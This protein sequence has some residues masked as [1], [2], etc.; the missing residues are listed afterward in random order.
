MKI[1]FVQPWDSFAPPDTTGALG[2]WSWEVARRFAGSHEVTVFCR[3][4][5]GSPANQ[6]LDG[7]RFRRFSLRLDERLLALMRRFRLDDEQEEFNSPLYSR[8]FLLRAILTPY[9][10][11]CDVLHIFNLSQFVPLVAR[12]NPRAKIVL[13]MH[14]DWLAGFD[15]SVMNHRLQFADSIIGCSNY[16]THEI[17]S[18]F[19]QHADRCQTVYNGADSN[20]FQPPRDDHA[21]SGDTLLTVGRISPEKGLHILLAAF[22]KVLERKPDTRLRIVGSESIMRPKVISVFE[23]TSPARDALNLYGD[24]YLRAL[25]EQAGGKLEGKVSFIGALPYEKVPA[26]MQN[27]SILV[28]PSLYET[29]GMPVAEAMAAGL[30][31]VASRAGG[32]AEIVSDGETGMLVEPNDPD[33]LAEALLVLLN[34]PGLA[35]SMG[36]AGRMRALNKFS[37]DATVKQ[38]H[39]HYQGLLN[40]DEQSQG[41]PERGRPKRRST[42]DRRFEE[43]HQHL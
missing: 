37:W 25:K 18:R 10:R 40:A 16:I 30:P 19:P 33:R 32:L 20:I 7:V 21:T 31:V 6:L 35:R 36:A 1:G 41:H 12:L 11:N 13:N 2:I 39:A 3:R 43:S 9:A 27:A 22:A 23:G 5:I 38:L 15:Y 34:N 14:C 28:Q 8:V 17:Q 29:F 42:P 26:E 4:S 24:H